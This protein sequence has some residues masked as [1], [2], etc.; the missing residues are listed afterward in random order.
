MYDEL[1]RMFKP[2]LIDFSKIV[3]LNLD[4]YWPMKKSSPYSDTTICNSTSSIM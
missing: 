2:G 1:I 3:T 4:E